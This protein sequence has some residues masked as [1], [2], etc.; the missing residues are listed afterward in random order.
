MLPTPLCGIFFSNERAGT[1]SLEF[2]RHQTFGCSYLSMSTKLY[3]A[4]YNE[5]L[6]VNINQ[7][8]VLKLPFSVFLLK[9]NVIFQP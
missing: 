2:P 7:S 8:L 9:K 1:L 5:Q 3:I 4:V 6:F